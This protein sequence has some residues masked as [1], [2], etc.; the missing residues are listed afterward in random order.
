[1]FL[2]EGN[3]MPAQEGF[4]PFLGSGSPVSVSG[5]GGTTAG[6]FDIEGEKV[7]R[8]GLMFG[9]SWI[10]CD[11]EQ[12]PVLAAGNRPTGVIYATVSHGSSAPELSVRSGGALPASTL[13]ATHRLLYKAEGH[14]SS[15]YW[16]D[17]RSAITVVAM[18]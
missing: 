13:E 10:E 14:G 11:D 9:R 7:V 12:L 8:C 4:A 18:D 3:Q 15:S 16:A 1:M 2:P 5:G 6:A 17:Y